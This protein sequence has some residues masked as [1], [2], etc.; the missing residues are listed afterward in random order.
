MELDAVK[1]AL[2]ILNGTN[3]RI[4]AIGDHLKALWN[5]LHMIAMAHPDRAA[6]LDE[7]AVEQRP[8]T[9]HALQLGMAVF[10]LAGRHHLAA[11]V[12]THQLHAVAD[13]EHGHAQFEQL[14]GDGR[15]T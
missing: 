1:I 2:D 9:V 4:R 8:G 3:R 15:R 12:L 6:A 10:A 5:D 7:E 14:F 13:T 11:E